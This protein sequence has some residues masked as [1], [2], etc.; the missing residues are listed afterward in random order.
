MSMSEFGCFFIE[1][2]IDY[3]DASNEWPHCLNHY[4]IKGLITDEEKSSC[5][6]RK[7]ASIL[8]LLQH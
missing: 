1:E 3:T 2:I 6:F 5:F 8:M 4:F 7:E